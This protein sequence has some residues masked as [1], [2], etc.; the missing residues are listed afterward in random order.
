MSLLSNVC[1][2]TR[3]CS[4]EL[5]CSAKPTGGPLAASGLAVG[6]GGPGPLQS[7][8]LPGA[9]P[10]KSGVAPEKARVPSVAPELASLPRV[11]VALR[12]PGV[13]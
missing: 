4:Y 7:P 3:L 10:G 1:L 6:E 8:G 11:G 5:H 2:T 13:F 9:Q 12:F